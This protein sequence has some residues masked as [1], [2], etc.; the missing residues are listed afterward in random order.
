M[1][2]CRLRS[3]RR[4]QLSLG[5]RH[6]ECRS[7]DAH[8]KLWPDTRSVHTP[9]MTLKNA[10][11]LALIGTM[12]MTALL[13]WVFV[14]NLVNVLRSVEA[15]VVLFSSFIYAVGLLYPEGVLFRVPSSAAVVVISAR[16]ALTITATRRRLEQPQW[17]LE[18]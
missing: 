2:F 11:L 8:R 5:T 3:N 15:P 1:D 7:V 16:T 14:S 4:E 18:V 6:C 13:V 10:A 9:V 17:F 12:L